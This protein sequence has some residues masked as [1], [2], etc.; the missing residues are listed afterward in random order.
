VFLGYQGTERKA[1]F[2]ERG[3]V[4]QSLIPIVLQGAEWN[5]E[6]QVPLKVPKFGGL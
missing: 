5:R 1:T 2:N 4:D 3:R 6:K